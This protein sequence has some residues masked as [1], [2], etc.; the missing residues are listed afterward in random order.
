[1]SDACEFV[2]QKDGYPWCSLCGKRADHSHLTSENHKKRKMDPQWYIPE[3]ALKQVLECFPDEA[4][5]IGVTDEGWP[6]C[7]LCSK[8]ATVEHMDSER[9]FQKVQ[10]AL[11]DGSQSDALPAAASAASGSST[12]AFTRGQRLTDF[13]VPEGAISGS[14]RRSDSWLINF[15][16]KHSNGMRTHS[17][18]IPWME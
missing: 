12:S 7:N 5:F 17:W 15:V 10:A 4:H 9:H 14:H 18:M 3:V 1:M 16:L 13:F 6:F 8:R 11:R 2:T